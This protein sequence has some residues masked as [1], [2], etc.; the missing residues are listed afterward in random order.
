[1]P[2]P[3]AAGCGLGF[4]NGRR[5][6]PPTLLQPPCAQQ[7]PLLP[8]AGR[9]LG[10]SGRSKPFPQAVGA[11]GEGREEGGP[12]W[13][14]APSGGTRAR[15]AGLRDASCHGFG[16]PRLR[17]FV[18]FPAAFLPAADWPRMRWRHGGCAAERLPCSGRGV[19]AAL[20]SRRAL[21]CEGL[22]ERCPW[23]A[24]SLRCSCARGTQ[25]P[26]RGCGSGQEGRVRV[27]EFCESCLR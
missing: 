15:G 16:M 5:V 2:A 7:C 23:V 27:C 21:G 26:L 25:T 13:A 20:C 11:A 8:S 6:P 18:R 19:R 10:P 24:V 9:A 4:P 22:R 14:G 3:G 1:M 17:C 12:L